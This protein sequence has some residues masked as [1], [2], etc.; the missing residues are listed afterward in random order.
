ML[1]RPAVPALVLVL[2]LSGSIALAQDSASPQPP[3]Y[4]PVRIEGM[5]TVRALQKTYGAEG[6]LAILHLNRIDLAHVREGATLVVPD[7]PASMTALS[8]F[9]SSLG[10]EPWIPPRLL[11]V[12]RRVQAFAA[13]EAGALVR[14]GATSTGRRDTPTPAG[15][16]AANWRSKLRRSSDNA[17]WLLP[18][19][20]NFVN[21][22]GVSFHQFA[23]PGS[24]A[25]HACVRLLVDDAKWIYDWTELW[26][27]DA[28]GR[29]IEVHGTPVLVF[30]DYEFDRPGPWTMLAED[31]NATVVALDEI[32]SAIAPHRETIIERTAV[33]AAWRP[34]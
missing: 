11:L 28:Q 33:R 18:W 27:L 3:R 7:P 31:A 21:E 15:L 10:Q 34:R 17:E 13:Y 20:V 24:P 16:F 29:R 22:S 32:R 23:L 25:S 9:P 14:W 12:S 8:P 26:V 6:F 4:R 5:A 19:Y 30:G 2:I 1:P